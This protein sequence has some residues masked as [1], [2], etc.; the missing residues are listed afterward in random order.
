MD[1]EAMINYLDSENKA[2]PSSSE[3]YKP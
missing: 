3:S 2:S 1:I